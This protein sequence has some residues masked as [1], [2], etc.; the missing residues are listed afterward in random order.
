[1]LRIKRESM[2]TFMMEVN[3]RPRFREDMLSRK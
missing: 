3:S 1:M 2:M